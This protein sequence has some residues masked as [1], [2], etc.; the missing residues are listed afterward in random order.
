MAREYVRDHPGGEV[1][2][3]D[4]SSTLLNMCAWHACAEEVIS[5]LELYGVAPDF[6]ICSI[7]TGG[8]FCGIAQVL[9]DKYKS[10]KTIGIEVCDSAPLYAARRGLVFEHCS[11]NLMG[12]GAGVLSVN[13][14][15]EL[16]DEVIVVEG[17][18]AWE[19]MRRFVS[20][21][22]FGVGPTCGANLMVCEHIARLN[23]DK[24]ILTLFFDSAWKYES[25]WDGVYPE[26]AEIK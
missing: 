5:E 18:A 12:L 26:Y 15:P 2:F 4:Q 7:G 3:L 14:R 6:F 20:E 9:K 25:R 17:D 21:D 8:T 22:D 10:I 24:N 23:S 11:H 16:I 19:R 1:V 13:T